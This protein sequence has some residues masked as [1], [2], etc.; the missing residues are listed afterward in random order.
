MRT[1]HPYEPMM[2][3]SGIDHTVKIFSPDQRAQWDARHGIHLARQGY[4]GRSSLG[5]TRFGRRR[6]GTDVASLTTASAA[7]RS[8]A[9]GTGS[10]NT[11]DDVDRDDDDDDAAEEDIASIPATNGGL[12]SRRRLHMAY[13]ITSQN[14]ERRQ[15]GRRETTISVSSSCFFFQTCYSSMM[16]SDVNSES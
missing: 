5:F 13:E 10:D 8:G 14:E 3:V 9:N 2:A 1:G 7:S 16:G 12:A 4:T 15:G 11:H 6:P